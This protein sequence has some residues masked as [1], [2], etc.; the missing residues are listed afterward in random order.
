M[1]D[2]LLTT[3]SLLV[4]T[5]NYGRGILKE[6]RS[7]GSTVIQ[8]QWG[9]ISVPAAAN[10]TFNIISN[11]GKRGRQWIDS[12]NDDESAQQDQYQQQYPYRK[13]KLNIDSIDNSNYSDLSIFTP[14]A[15]NIDSPSTA[16]SA[17][18]IMND[19]D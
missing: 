19:F 10:N 12:S 1:S 14:I 6:S 18:A 7:D 9:T 3:K 16:N 15:T 5:L 17:A 11:A 8:F 13:S 2:S 4:N